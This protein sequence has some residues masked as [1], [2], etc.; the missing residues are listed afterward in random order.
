MVRGISDTPWFPNAYQGTVAARRAARVAI[1]IATR[2]P[3]KVRKA[4]IALDDL[5]ATANASRAGYLIAGQAYFDVGEVTRVT[6]TDPQGSQQTLEGDAL[7]KMREH[8]RLE[9]GALP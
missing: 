6:Y 1:R 4:P 5:S 9:A 7:A 3:A 8:Y 2:L